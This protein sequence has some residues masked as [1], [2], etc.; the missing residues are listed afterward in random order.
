L[1][2]IIKRNSLQLSN[3]NF[4]EQIYRLQDGQ[5]K[6]YRTKKAVE[7]C[8]SFSLH[9]TPTEHHIYE[10]IEIVNNVNKVHKHIEVIRL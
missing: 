8:N 2:K 1:I 10:N 5:S 3:E 6:L 4:D 7:S 9:F